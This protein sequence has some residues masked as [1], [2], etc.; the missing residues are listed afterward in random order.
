MESSSA[1]TLG[2]PHRR[3]AT[4]RKW[5]LASGR[6]PVCLLLHLMRLV[7]RSRVLLARAPFGH[8]PAPV[9]ETLSLPDYVAIMLRVSQHVHAACFHSL[10][11]GFADIDGAETADR[12]ATASTAASACAAGARTATLAVAGYAALAAAPAASGCASAGTGSATLAATQT[13]ARSGTGSGT[14]GIIREAGIRREAVGTA[15][16]G[17]RWAI[18]VE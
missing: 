7:R 3:F 18:A 8:V 16:T 2:F 14:A 12:N 11:S 10:A 6:D 4:Q 9:D 1:R 15:A 5:G 17:A 13:A